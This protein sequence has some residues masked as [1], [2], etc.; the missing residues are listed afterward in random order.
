MMSI[1]LAWQC[2]AS[3]SAVLGGILACASR[4]IAH[5][6]KTKTLSRLGSYLF[7]I[8]T[9]FYTLRNCECLEPDDQIVNMNPL[10]RN[11]CDHCNDLVFKA[12]TSIAMQRRTTIKVLLHLSGS[13]HCCSIL[14]R[15]LAHIPSY[16]RA[17]FDIP[18]QEVDDFP[19]TI[20]QTA[21]QS[22]AGG[23]LSKLVTATLE[24]SKMFIYT[25]DMTIA[26]CLSN[27]K[28]AT[29]LKA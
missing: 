20:S 16:V 5:N 4:F 26:W 22:S 29:P 15:I 11:L 19:L 21:P 23:I 9:R 1:Q 17:R 2:F 8:L 14:L 24:T 3:S 10:Q 25:S 7:S 12:S 27:C 6:Y 13:C 18:N 28:F